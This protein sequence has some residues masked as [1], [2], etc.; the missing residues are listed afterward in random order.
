M[1]DST[2]H[3]S[4]VLITGGSGLVG[5]YLTSILLEKGYEVAHLSRKQG[6]FGRVR[7]YRWSPEKKI[8]DPVVLKGVD[9]IVH[10]AGEGIGEGRWSTKRK[11]EIL[12]SRTDSAIL[13]HSV[14]MDNKIPISSF[15]SASGISYYGMQTTTTILTEKDPP[16]S[17]FLAMVCHRWEEA[18]GLFEKT[19]IRTVKIRTPMVLEK[20][21]PA[22]KNL[23][24]PARLGIVVRMGTGKQYMPWIHINDLCRVYVKAIEDTSL[25]GVFNA[26]APDHVT[27]DQFIRTLAKITKKHLFPLNIPSFL[28][29]A[30][31]GEKAGLV[32]KGSR[33]SSDK[34]IATG[35]SFSY[36]TLQE[37][38]R[39]VLE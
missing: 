32:L 33:V 17:D 26:S 2:S 20:E 37:A 31:F 3:K 36:M 9:H 5:K 24:L 7:V 38:L 21:S 28:L 18:A 34:L 27:H 19:G 23:L 12:R 15:I 11:E 4:K 35:F 6:Q 13:L 10:L 22:L 39:D 30:A 1:T 25:A 16:A 8:I 14:I 29:S